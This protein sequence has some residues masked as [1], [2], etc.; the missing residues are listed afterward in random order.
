M[1]SMTIVNPRSNQSSTRSFEMQTTSF[2]LSGDLILLPAGTRPRSLF[3]ELL[4]TVTTMADK[5]A[6]SASEQHHAI[7]QSKLTR[8]QHAAHK[9]RH[10]TDN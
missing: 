6:N 1:S 2:L 9:K 10:K 5:R 7:V 8:L 4:D 3:K